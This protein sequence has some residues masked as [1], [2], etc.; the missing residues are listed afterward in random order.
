MQCTPV[1]WLVIGEWVGASVHLDH[2]YALDLA[3]R[4][5]GY[6][7]GLVREDAVLE[8]VRGAVDA[9]K[10]ELLGKGNENG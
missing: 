9:T 3:V 2:A 1:A 8:A 7:V 6:V 10:F 4:Q 5:H